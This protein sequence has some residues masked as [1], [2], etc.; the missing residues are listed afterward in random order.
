MEAPNR[1]LPRGLHSQPLSP[2]PFSLLPDPLPSLFL[3]SVSFF[4]KPSPAPSSSLALAFS[5]PLLPTTFFSLW[6]SFFLSPRAT[7]TNDYHPPATAVRRH[8]PAR[9][10]Q[11]V[12]ITLSPAGWSPNHGDGGACICVVEAQTHSSRSPSSDEFHC[13]SWSQQAHLDP[14]FKRIPSLLE[15]SSRIISTHFFTKLTNFAS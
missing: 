11:R 14:L 8:T 10:V 2:S 15:E 4:G 12:L 3:S 1:G 6:I 7:T 5:F 13:G 9:D